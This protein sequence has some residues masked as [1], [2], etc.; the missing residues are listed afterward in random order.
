MPTNEIIFSL[1]ILVL[2]ICIS[3]LGFP[4]S[5]SRS[6]ST[7][8]TFTTSVHNDNNNNNGN[9]SNHSRSIDML[10]KVT[11]PVARRSTTVHMCHGT[12]VPAP[13]DYLEQPD[14]EETKAF[15]KAQNAAFKESIADASFAAELREQMTT[16][17]NY[18]RIGA[19]NRGRSDREFYYYNNPGLLN[20]SVLMRLNNGL[21]DTS[22]EEVFFDVN[23]LSEDAGTT[24]LGSTGWSHSR[25]FWAYATTEKGSDWNTIHVRDADLPA[26]DDKNPKDLVKWVKFSG[27]S[28]IHD[29]G[30]F[31]TRFP[32]PS[33]SDAGTETT[34]TQDGAVYFH[35]LG[36]SQDD[37]VLVAKN[38][39]QP[40]WLPGIGVTDDNKYVVLQWSDGCE[41]KNLLWIA[42]IPAGIATETTKFPTDSE[43]NWVK[44]VDKWVAEY[45]VVGNDNSVFYIKT[46]SNFCP[47]GALLK[48]DLEDVRTKGATIEKNAVVLVA[49]DP[50]WPLEAAELVAGNYLLL[51]YLENVKHVFYLTQ[52]GPNKE[53][54]ASRKVQLPL[55][56]GSVVGWAARRDSPF[57]AIKMASFTLPGRSIYFNLPLGGTEPNSEEKLETPKLTVW[58]DEGPAGFNGDDFVVTQHFYKSESGDTL[59]PMFVCRH[60]SV[61]VPDEGKPA[62]GAA[63]VASSGAAK[64]NANATTII[65]AY[66][67]FS[68]SITPSFSLNAF[69]WMN[70][71]K[72]VYAVANIRGGAELGETWADA[73]KR[74]NK[75]N[76]YT[77]LAAG[78]RFLQTDLRITTPAKTAIMGGSNGGLVVSATALREPH[79]FGAV[80]AQV[81]VLDIFRFHLFTIG[82]AWRSDFLDPDIEAEFRYQAKYSPVHNVRSNVHYP[83]MLMTCGDHD[84]RVVPLHSHIF[85][86][87][88]QHTS[89]DFGGPFLERIDEAAGHGAG[90]PLSKIIDEAVDTYSFL[91]LALGAK[92]Q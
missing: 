72:G 83:A 30:F 18:R 56:I 9:K 8:T 42:E 41:K 15:V 68:V 75:M 40:E 26:D 88:L 11:Y 10:R 29:I 52:L 28:W 81:G 45:E 7:T 22:K 19:P 25:K 71:F 70:R 5:S 27:I 2:A 76:C 92:W 49:E 53:S 58:Q 89:P 3:V 38:P 78:A 67:G 82:N 37:D 13:Y 34:K 48:I 80:V 86:A 60:K 59:V 44:L 39:A 69:I 21:D 23:K 57:V 32:K 16:L 12:P 47:N 84:D 36:T 46:L 87:T 20:Q 31:Y 85:T 64:P 55:P 51:L 43:W 6:K 73:G 50:K 33:T 63:A 24:A 1:F 90:K 14:V 66:G 54:I 4:P 61:V 91:A 74:F 17:R 35:K 65:S 79:L 62:D 77:D